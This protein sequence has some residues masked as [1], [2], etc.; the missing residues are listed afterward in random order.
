MR[1]IWFA[2]DGE[3]VVEV[4]D[5]TRLPHEMAVVAWSTVE[6]AARGIETMQVR[7]APLI[8]V[9]A[10][11]GVFL[12]M[13]SDPSDA[14]LTGAIGRLR[15]TRPTAVNLGWALDQVEAELRPLAP[16][17]RAGAARA[18]AARLADEDVA[19]CRAIGEA[20]LAALVDAAG[21]DGTVNVLTHCNAGWLATVDWGTALAPI[22]RAHDDGLPVRVAVSETRPR[23]QGA[24]TAWELAGHGV[25]HRLVADNAAGHLLAA[26]EIDVVITGADRIA[27]NGDVANKIGT[28]LKA[29]AARASGVPFLVAAPCSTIDRACPDGSAIPIEERPPD[30]VRLVVGSTRQ[31]GIDAVRVVGGDT[32]VANPAFDVTPAALVTALITER[33]VVPA[34]TEGIASLFPR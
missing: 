33:G 24:L 9:S 29:L 27:A 8:G 5:Q 6:D 20:G 18:L 2:A 22:Y 7:G 30:E 13:A 25:P 14:A 4:I 32:P 17:Q 10:A 21:P 31:G 34:T 19:A 1:T 28:Y 16:A 15:R 26:G 12:A 3:D 23:N 11:H